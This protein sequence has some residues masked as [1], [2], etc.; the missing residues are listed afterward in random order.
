MRNVSRS[1]NRLADEDR[2]MGKPVINAGTD[3]QQTVYEK[4]PYLCP[5]LVELD[6]TSTKGGGRT[7][8]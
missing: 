2:A 4:L 1:E 5:S 8:K 6:L 7:D 3:H